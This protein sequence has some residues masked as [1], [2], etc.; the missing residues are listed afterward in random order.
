VIR[1]ESTF[2]QATIDHH[3]DLDNERQALV[4]EQELHQDLVVLSDLLDT[5]RHLPIKLIKAIEL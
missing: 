5:Y 3:Q 1:Y 4:K 2:D